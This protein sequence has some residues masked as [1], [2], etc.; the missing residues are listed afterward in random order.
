M[1][2]P[3]YSQLSQTDTM[4]TATGVNYTQSP[5]KDQTVLEGLMHSFGVA[6]EM[7]DRRTTD[8]DELHNALAG[9]LRNA[10]AQVDAEP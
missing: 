6:K 3:S 4:R 7:A 5:R 1:P 10:P 9:S 8:P 2:Q